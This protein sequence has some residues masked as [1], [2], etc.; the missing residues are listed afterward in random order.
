[1]TAYAADGTVSTGYTGTVH[2]SS[3]DA[4]AALPA[5]YTFTGTDAGVHQFSVMLTTAGSQGVTA[6]DPS[7]GSLSASQT[8]TISPA[9][10]AT[11]SLSGLSSATAGALQT[12]TVTLV[13]PYGNVATGYTG[14]VHF[15]STD[16]L[17]SLPADY[18]FTGADAGVHQFSVA[19]K[20]AGSQSVTAADTG[21]GS[22][23][24][25][26][27]LTISPAAAASLTLS[28]L[29]NSIAGTGQTAT[30][31]LYDAYGNTAS[32]YRGTMAFSSSDVQAALP[33]SY[34][35][36]GG[37]AGVHR[38]SVTLKTAGLQ[39]VT[40]RD[41]TA[42]AL[43]STQMIQ[44]TAASAANVR[45][46]VPSTAKANQP[47]TAT[48]TLRDQ[49]ANLASGYRGALHF[50]SS[51]LVAQTLGDLPPDYTFTSGDAGTHTFSVKLATIGSQ[52]I[53]VRDTANGALTVTSG[54]IT[55]T[56][57]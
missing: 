16:A 14:A 45:I 40:A 12:A 53:T 43:A 55:V 32:G 39:A 54:S 46:V 23:T 15:S 33:A 31:A 5:D 38:F 11:L 18:A 2:F 22:L 3:S 20:K 30:V 28:G 17:A 6:A 47:F 10:A 7:T 42:S 35:F 9:P 52:T 13:D 19:L 48:V 41:A 4:F 8:L 44:I 51:D 26:Q 27:T 57:M 34:T 24:A 50:T 56:L 37:D 1:V 29:T 49:F 21:N 25:A 36:T